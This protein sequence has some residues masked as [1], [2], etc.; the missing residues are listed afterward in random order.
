MLD[1]ESVIVVGGG[2]AGL[3][4]ATLLSNEGVSVILI[5]AHSQLGG[6][7]GTFR[8]G[9]YIFDVGATQVAGFESG[10]IHERLFRYLKCSLPKATILD[11]ACSVDLND[12]LSP[13][14]LWY[15]PK[16]WE[17][18]RKKHFP[19]SDRFWNLCEALHK[20]NWSI[21][22]RDPI[23]PIRNFWDM[24][25]FFQA[26][27][28]ENI[29]SA[30]FTRLSII[31][32]LKFSGSYQDQRLVKFLDMQLKLYSQ[33]SAN[34]TSALYGATVLQIA[35]APLGL[36]HLDGSMQQLSEIMSNC[37]LRNGGSLLLSNRV[38]A[39]SPKSNSPNWEV[40]I[41]DNKGRVSILKTSDIVFSLPPQALIDLIP[42][43]SEL[44]QG[45]LN[46]LKQLSQPS[47]A[48]VFYGAINRQNFSNEL[49][50]HLQFLSNLFGSIFISIS[51]EGDGRAPNDQATVIASIFVNVDDWV[52]L[53][54]KQYD[55]K[56]KII[57]EQMLKEL[58][59]SLDI[60]SSSWL[61]KELAT[62]KSFLTWTGR[63]K[64][65][66]GGLGQ[67]PTNFGPFGLASRSPMKGLWLCGDSIYPGE[68][69]A[70]VSQSALMACRQLLVA[71]G[72]P[73]IN[74]PN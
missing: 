32:L 31:D 74:L 18:E 7:A 42:S 49:P 13:I 67:H 41:I 60:S 63:P 53:N 30:L 68:G 46:H 23:L 12:G 64:G 14:L 44:N 40:E 58:E 71:K 38:V 4:A 28:L 55:A 72:K 19:G 25:K 24:K 26:I 27:R 36:S 5:E 73:D 69:T 39:L 70:G 11:P 6:C 50:S 1:T 33:E 43:A 37:F 9:P 29:P 10:G 54:K 59:K 57:M 48:I 62:P 66:V 65:I 51:Q 20:S 34:R 21:A 52:C 47:G 15:D 35:Q 8:R 3:T 45:Y 16:K 17:E 2:I 56:K 22:S 61:H